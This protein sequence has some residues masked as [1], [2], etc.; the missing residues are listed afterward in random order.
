VRAL[1]DREIVIRL[2]TDNDEGRLVDADDTPTVEVFDGAGEAITGVSSVAGEGTGTYKATIPPRSKLDVLT[3]KWTAIVDG[4]TRTVAEGVRIVGGRLA[5]LWRLR[6]TAELKDLS[7]EELRRL[8]DAVDD[9]FASALGF[10]PVPEP[11]RTR[12]TSFGGQ[13]LIVPGVIFPLDMYEL[14]QRGTALSSD[15]LALLRFR[16]GYVAWSDA[17]NWIADEVAAW[18]SHGWNTP[19]QDLRDAAVALAVYASRSP[20]RKLPERATRVV[21][22][23]ADISLGLPSVDH[24]TGIPDVDA[25]IV[26]RRVW[27]PV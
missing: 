26:R 21:T 12:F 19:T 2:R 22:E 24:P 4:H 8:A 25:A 9:W 17:R 11:I 6:E 14:A 10:P 15:E 27:V 7:G 23:G 18:M 5:E 3:A 13:R 16:F 20:D 1:V